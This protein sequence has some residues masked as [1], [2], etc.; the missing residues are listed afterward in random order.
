MKQVTITCDICGE[1]C[2]P[3][4][5]VSTFVYAL[6]VMG[7]DKVLRPGIKQEEYCGS[8]TEKMKYALDQLKEK[9]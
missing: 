4:Q 2:D 5:E 9:K 6:H 1:L 8:C 3:R 7:T